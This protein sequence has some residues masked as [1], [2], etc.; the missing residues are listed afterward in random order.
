MSFS[1]PKWGVSSFVANI[2]P[3]LAWWHTTPWW[4]LAM[5]MLQVPLE[6]WC[7]VR[8]TELWVG[9]HIC[10]WFVVI[11]IWVLCFPGHPR[12]YWVISTDRLE[13]S[14]KC[15]C[16]VWTTRILRG[17]Q[18]GVGKGTW[19]QWKCC[20]CCTEVMEDFRE[21][22][23]ETSH[24]VKSWCNEL[25]QEKTCIKKCVFFLLLLQLFCLQKLG[26]SFLFCVLYCRTF[27]RMCL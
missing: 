12:V 13:V 19:A 22:W 5:G 9:W 23:N 27:L 24:E 15:C 7:R 4:V 20:P 26:L 16:T 1:F 8:T 2:N 3:P 25:C 18:E 6:C 14:T 10:L 17:D 21:F 11:S